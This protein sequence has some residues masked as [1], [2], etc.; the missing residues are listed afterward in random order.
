MKFWKKLSVSLAV[1]ALGIS[2]VAPSVSAASVNSEL[3]NK[4]RPSPR[5]WA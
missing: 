5:R 2:A 3:K 4:G 1:A